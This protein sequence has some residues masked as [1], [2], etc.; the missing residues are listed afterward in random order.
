MLRVSNGNLTI[1]SFCHCAINA[2]PL[3][4][5]IQKIPPLEVFKYVVKKELY[6][7]GMFY[8]LIIL[9]GLPNSLKELTCWALPTRS[10]VC[11]H[12]INS[13]TSSGCIPTTA[14]CGKFLIMEVIHAVA[15]SDIG[16]DGGD[17]E[18]EQNFEN[19]QANTMDTS[20]SASARLKYGSLDANRFSECL[21][22]VK[23]LHLKA[24]FHEKL[25]NNHRC[26]HSQ[27][28]PRP[29]DFD[30]KYVVPKVEFARLLRLL[31]MFLQLKVKD[32]ASFTWDL[33]IV[34]LTQ[35]TSLLWLWRRREGTSPS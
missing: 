29:L 7:L 24:P 27:L 23:H 20:R 15:D 19:K 4:I 26:P 22:L 16:Q 30:F 10:H 8:L 5:Y 33:F 11:G 9:R 14:A 35:I 13:A 17:D 12:W 25:H 2:S 3:S 21:K 6:Y 32:L 34:Q 18:R 31:S 1:L 28:H